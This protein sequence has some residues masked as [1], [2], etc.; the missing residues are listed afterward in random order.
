MICY[1][2]LLF[3]EGLE[4][5]NKGYLINNRAIK[6]YLIYL[7]EEKCSNCG[8]G[9]YWDNKFLSIQV[10]HIDG[11]SDN[12]SKDNVRLLCPNCHSQTPTFGIK[13]GNKNKKDNRNIYR[14][15]YRQK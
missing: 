3:L 14:K 5:F 2:E 15:K 10:D 1:Q 9:N 8:L 12:N 7:Y 4:K 11:N 6:K 13:G